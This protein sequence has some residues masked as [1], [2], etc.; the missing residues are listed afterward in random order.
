MREEDT[1]RHAPGWISLR[2]TSQRAPR[3][4]CARWGSPSL[5][6]RAHQHNERFRIQIGERQS[7]QRA[8]G[9]RTTHGTRKRDVR[10][11]TVVLHLGTPLRWNSRQN[12]R[13]GRTH[14]GDRKHAA[15]ATV[16][17]A[18]VRGRPGRLLHRQGNRER[19]AALARIVLMC[20]VRFDASART[21]AAHAAP[22]AYTCFLSRRA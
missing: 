15:Q 13:W 20:S 2:S 9:Y 7:E 18:G 3:G 16:I 14:S 1:D 4:R 5:R 6:P 10:L 19:R 12:S 21:K 22:A 17:L 11:Q 8:T